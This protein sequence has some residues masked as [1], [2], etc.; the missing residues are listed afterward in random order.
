MSFFQ[1]QSSTNLF[2]LKEG[3][4]WCACFFLKFMATVPS[5]QGKNEP[6]ESDDV[7]QRNDE[8]S[9]GSMIHM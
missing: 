8:A 5:C 2:F 3:V 7:K 6:A 4:P 1:G 9:I